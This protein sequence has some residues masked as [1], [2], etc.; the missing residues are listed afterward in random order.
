MTT[1]ARISAISNSNTPKV[2]ATVATSS[3]PLQQQ[4]Q[5]SLSN[6]PFAALN[7]ADTA[8]VNPSSALPPRVRHIERSFNE[9]ENHDD[10]DD[11]DDEYITAGS[12]EEDAGSHQSSA[13]ASSSSR[14]RPHQQ[15]HHFR[16]GDSAVDDAVAASNALVGENI[17]DSPR[18]SPSAKNHHSCYNN[19]NSNAATSPTTAAG[20]QG[21]WR[22]RT[23]S[24]PTPSLLTTASDN[25]AAAATST[26]DAMSVGI[27]AQGLAWARR[28]RERRQ[29]LYLQN[30]AEQQ[31]LKI[32]QAQLQEQQQQQAAT[33]GG[34][35][36]NSHNG[37]GGRSLLD[38]PTFQNY[39]ITPPITA[40]RTSSYDSSKDV[41]S[42][43]EVAGGPGRGGSA[44]EVG[45]D[46][47]ASII[48]ISK[49]VSKSGGGYSVHVPLEPDG[50]T[51]ME[52]EEDDAAWIP[53]VRVEEEPDSIT[54]PYILSASEMQEIAVHC[55]PRGIAYCRWKRVYSLARD[56]DSFDACLRAIHDQR[57]NIL[58]IRTSR[59]ER[60]GG[61]ADA[62]W[63][64][65]MQGGARYFGGSG[66]CLFRIV[67]V[68]NGDAADNSA[69]AKNANTRVEC[70]HWTGANRYVQLCDPNSKMLAFGGGG[71]QGAFGLCIE[72][73]FQIGSTGT[74]ATFNNAP[75]CEQENFQVIN[76]EIYGFLV[77]Q[78]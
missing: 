15:Q 72:Q 64:P 33:S 29:R 5:Q 43:Q 42:G 26:T 28:Q 31:L 36:F 50:N 4:Q 78:F 40:R 22:D 62:A 14:A 75:L 16:R 49:L 69:A 65:H 19:N 21:R 8:V 10:E 6:S 59:N 46:A 67:P 13:S 60:F 57:H 55:L 68:D 30:Q 3:V 41:G 32:R 2:T 44:E 17:L 48:D 27:M 58:V 77:G 63:E 56:G 54:N 74:C 66:A 73:D 9:N 39:F 35:P 71:Q 12:E 38:N 45:D 20:R 23:L 11:D 1:T 47:D 25:H 24:I 37:G 51:G 61:F 7:D 76:M 70:F 34:E 52:P 53:P 18:S